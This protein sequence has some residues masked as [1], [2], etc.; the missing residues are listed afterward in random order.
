MSNVLPHAS[1]MVYAE[2]EQDM[3]NTVLATIGFSSAEHC[4]IYLASTIHV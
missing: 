3:I 2:N 1:R 4:L